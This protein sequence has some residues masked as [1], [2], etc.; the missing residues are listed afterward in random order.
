MHHL[1]RSLM[2]DFR[3]TSFRLLFLPSE[4]LLLL[5][6]RLAWWMYEC[7]GLEQALQAF[8]GFVAS[9]SPCDSPPPVPCTKKR[10]QNFDATP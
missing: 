3:I 8:C 2:G 10:K 9:T 7:L 5:L 1:H 4:G 6:G